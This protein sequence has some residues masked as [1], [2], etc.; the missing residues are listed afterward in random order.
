[1]S[2]SE[3]VKQDSLEAQQITRKFFVVGLDFSRDSLAELD[4]LA[5]TIEI[6][7]R[8]GA[9]PENV[10]LLVRVW[11]AYVGEV[12]AREGDGQWVEADNE[13]GAALVA[14]VG[15]VSPHDRVRLRITAG[16]EHSLVAFAETL[17]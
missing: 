4:E 10:A 11:G 6:S 2:L 13:H 1:M 14:S 16:S 8:G 9:N 15:T 17:K 12:L 3:R 5:D 7:M